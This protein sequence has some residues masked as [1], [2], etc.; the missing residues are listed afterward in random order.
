MPA[1]TAR[2]IHVPGWAVVAVTVA[3]AL[4]SAGYAA[5]QK[6]RDTDAQFEVINYRLCRIERAV[7]VEPWMRCPTTPP[8]VT[9]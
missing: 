4:L 3:V 8:Q 5:G 7:N 1:L 9:R 2:S 6:E